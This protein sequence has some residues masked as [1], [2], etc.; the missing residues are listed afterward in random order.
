MEFVR[1]KPDVWNK[2]LFSVEVGIFYFVRS[3]TN[4]SSIIEL[5]MI[6]KGQLLQLVGKRKWCLL[7]LPNLTMG[8]S[9][10]LS[11]YCDHFANLKNIF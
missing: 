4:G 10:V 9:N 8:F 2:L 7:E 1:L 6:L 5:E 3:L 11:F